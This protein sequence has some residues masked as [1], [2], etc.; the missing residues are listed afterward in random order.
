[1]FFV[2]FL[3]SL[4]VWISSV[5]FDNIYQMLQLMESVVFFFVLNLPGGNMFLKV[6]QGWTIAIFL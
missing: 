5:A 4:P 1:M 6:V 3:N 2:G